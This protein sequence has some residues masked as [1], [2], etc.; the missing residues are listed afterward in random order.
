MKLKIKGKRFDAFGK[1]F[2][3]IQIVEQSY[4]KPNIFLSQNGWTIKA[5][6]FPDIQDTDKKIWLR[7]EN[8]SEDNKILFTERP[9]EVIAALREFAE[10]VADNPVATDGDTFTIEN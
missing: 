5:L 3:A 1:Q 4:R 10:H 8:Q 6:Y 7:G 2:A 9:D